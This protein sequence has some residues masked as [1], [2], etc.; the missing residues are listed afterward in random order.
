MKI[1]NSNVKSVLFYGPE[2]WKLDYKEKQKLRAFHHKCLRQIL[3]IF[4][5]TVISSEELLR[6]AQEKDSGPNERTQVEMG[7]SYTYRG[8]TEKSGPL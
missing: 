5:H 7:Q 1:F 6:K 8:R 3:R 4:W 2:S